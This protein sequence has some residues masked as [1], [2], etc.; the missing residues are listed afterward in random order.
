MERGS[1]LRS[2]E[3]KERLLSKKGCSGLGAADEG[4]KRGCFR[5]CCGSTDNFWNGFQQVS[6][7]LYKMGRSDPR[8]VFFAMKMGLSLTVVSLL[9]LFKEPLRGVS[10]Y[11]V[12]AILTVVLVFEFSVGATL[13]KG[14]N[15]AIGTFSAGAIALGIAELSIKSGEYEE[16]VILISIF[17]TGF[18]SSYCKLYPRVKPYEYGF[19]VFL[20]TFCIV[21]VSGN[22]SRNFIHT[23]VFRLL[24]I[25]FGAG[26]SMIINI[27]IYPI[28]SG[29]DLHKLVV[30][31]FKNA[32]S[33]LEGCVNGYLQCVEYER[34]SSNILTYQASDDPLYSAYRSV[35]Q[36][37]CQEE[38]LLNFAS[39]E[40]PHGPYK[41]FNYPWRNYVKVSGALRHCQFMVMAMHG[42]MLSE[43][44][45]PPEKRQVFA[46]EIKRVGNEGAKVVRELGAKVE[47]MEKLSPGDILRE[48]HEAGEDLQMKI[49][50]KSYLL[51]NSETWA[52]PLHNKEHEEEAKDDEH[53]LN[54]KSL[55]DISVDPSDVVIPESTMRKLSWPCLSFT[56]DALLPQPR[57]SKIYQSASSLSLATFTS[58]LIEFVARL[59]NLVDAFQELSELADFKVPLEQPLEKEVMGCWNR[60][61]SCFQSNK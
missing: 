50:D 58:L 57:E 10:Q 55:S 38:T 12:W 27:C 41:S 33:S 21:L 5:S 54:M 45:A 19:R 47:K 23:A 24:H 53:K 48:V 32:A 35:V 7:K 18:I 15:R 49:D 13:S 44:Q 4:A 20:L 36:S 39:W 43:I 42:C 31:N 60:L 16:I 59:Q 17:I 30:K 1:F 28:W 9:M 25:F 34:I 56:A 52:T 2:T 6:A 51:V 22:N 29:E 46:V 14:I 26:L 40:P 3:S 8:K 11:S 37:S 61:T